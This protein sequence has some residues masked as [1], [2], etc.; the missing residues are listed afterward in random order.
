MYTQGLIHN[1]PQKVLQGLCTNCASAEHCSY[2][3]AT[4]KIIIQCEI[5]ELNNLV[6]QES[7][8]PRPGGLCAS[9]V[10]A[11]FCQLPG[12]NVGVWHCEEYG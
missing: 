9:C 8:L 10:H 5:F 11:A 3:K 4:D 6:A 1:L 2:R 12:R 7:V